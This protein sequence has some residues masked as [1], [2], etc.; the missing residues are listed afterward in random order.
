MPNTETL[1]F[2]NLW[3]HIG[4][5]MPKAGARKAGKLDPRAIPAKLQT[6]LNALYGHY[7]KTFEAWQREG[8]DVPPVFIVVCNNTTTSQLVYEWIAGFE[9]EVEGEQPDFQNGQLKL[10]RNYD[11]YNRRLPR[12]NTLLIDSEQLESGEALDKNFRDM[13]VARSR[14]NCSISGPAAGGDEHLRPQGQA[15]RGHTLRR[16]RLHGDGRVGQPRRPC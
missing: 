9:R 6:A 8:I 7:E 15:R 13:G 12:P 14:L 4:R 10:F 5:E 11:E 1:T 3:D 16:L 2:R